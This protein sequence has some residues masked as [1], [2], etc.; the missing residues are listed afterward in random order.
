VA[1]AAAGDGFALSAADL[2]CD[3]A[4]RILGFEPGFHD[5]EFLNSYISTGLYADR[6][7]A[8]KML[9]GVGVL[10]GAAGFLVAPL[11]RFDEFDQPDLVVIRATPYQA[12]R[13][14]QASGYHGR[15]VSCEPIG[16]HGICAESVASTYGDHHVRLSLLCSNARSASPWGDESLAVSIAFSL[17][18]ETVVG[19][20]ATMQRYESDQGKARIRAAFASAQSRSD[21]LAEHVEA[22]RDGEAY[23]MTD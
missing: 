22:L 7:A 5:V 12:M 15:R 11:S 13:L 20:L 14:V 9:S 8:E 10:D 2:S 19:L 4:S 21:L 6:G 3:T 23:F 16:M 1:H 18:L 17:L